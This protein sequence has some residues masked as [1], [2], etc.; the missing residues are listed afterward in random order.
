MTEH[1]LTRAADLMRRHYGRLPATGPAGYWTTLVCVVLDHG[2]PAKKGRDWSWLVEG[3]LRTSEETAAQGASRLIELLD[4]N[5]QPSSK[6]GVLCG[7]ASWWQ[8]RFGAED[9][10]ADFSRRS[11]GSWQ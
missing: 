11:L 4:E 8:S 2:R 3:P 5:N 7:C 6:A 9:A 1:V 10:P